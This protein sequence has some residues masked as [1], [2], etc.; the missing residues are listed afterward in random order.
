[1]TTDPEEMIPIVKSL[2]GRDAGNVYLVLRQEGDFYFLCDGKKRSPTN[3]K[4]KR[5][6]HVRQIGEIPRE[7]AQWP[8]GSPHRQTDTICADIRK[9][10]TEW[11][12]AQSSTKEKIR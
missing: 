7:S 11:T 5:K 12:E 8:D 6:K 1:M 2:I 9:S 4:K 10:I 3:A